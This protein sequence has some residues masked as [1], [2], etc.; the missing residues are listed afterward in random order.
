MFAKKFTYLCNDNCFVNMLDQ[1]PWINQWFE[2]VKLK[3][4][5][6]SYV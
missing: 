2:D 4:D 5:E 3:Q 6:K 1:K